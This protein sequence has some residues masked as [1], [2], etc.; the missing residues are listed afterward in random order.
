MV[1]L[2]ALGKINRVLKEFSSQKSLSAIDTHLLKGF[3]TNARSELDVK[4]NLAIATLLQQNTSK[5]KNV[6]V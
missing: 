2:F 4:P 5:P 1:R 6:K 3:Y